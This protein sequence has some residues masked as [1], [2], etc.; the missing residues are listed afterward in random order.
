MCHVTY[1][2]PE[3]ATKYDL[4]EYMKHAEYRNYF[5]NTLSERQ[6]KYVK[7]EMD[8]HFCLIPKWILM[9]NNISNGETVQQRMEAVVRVICFIYFIMISIFTTVKFS[10]QWDIIP[11][12]I[13][14]AEFKEFCYICACLISA[15]HQ[16]S[17]QNDRT[18]YYKYGNEF[19]DVKY[20]WSFKQNDVAL[21]W[22]NSFDHTRKHVKLGRSNVGIVIDR[23]IKVTMKSVDASEADYEV[24]EF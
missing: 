17:N 22:F 19:G 11:H 16:H 24:V 20:I 13:G 10:S 1:C 15:L 2:S 3:K 8:G 21:Q 6:Q 12:L 7:E 5:N 9:L 4:N 18:A 23:V 14:D